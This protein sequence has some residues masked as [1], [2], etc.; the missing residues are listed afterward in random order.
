MPRVDLGR[1][2]VWLGSIAGWPL[3]DE[4]AAAREVESCGYGTI[5][6]GESPTTREA[7]VHAALLLAGTERIA[8]ATGIAS[9][10][11]RTPVA[12][13]AAASTLEE[14]HPGRFVL[15]LGV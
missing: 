2:G 7:F 8:V 4:L 5:W 15:G 3:A 9:I 11:A 6:F 13:A 10:W 1:V 14:A 12:A